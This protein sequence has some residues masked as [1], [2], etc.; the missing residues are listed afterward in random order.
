MTANQSDAKLVLVAGATGGTG[1]H[2]VTELL[3]AGYR[4]R[5]LTSRRLP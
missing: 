5:A 2:V 1:R 3:A 4:V